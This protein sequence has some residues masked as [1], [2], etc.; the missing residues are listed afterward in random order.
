M[1]FENWVFMNPGVSPM[2]LLIFAFIAV[3]ALRP[4]E[5]PEPAV[6]AANAPSAFAGVNRQAHLS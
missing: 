2:G 5:E 3:E 4:S 6:A 1:A